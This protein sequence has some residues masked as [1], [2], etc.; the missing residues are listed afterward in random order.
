MHAV[1]AITLYHDSC[2]MIPS[3]DAYF[4]F[5]HFSI[6]LSA[7]VTVNHC[8]VLNHLMLAGTGNDNPVNL[9]EA[10]IVDATMISDLAAWVSAR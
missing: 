1:S 9:L 5:L 6:V 3:R 2:G 8:P 4:I 10:Q 7:D